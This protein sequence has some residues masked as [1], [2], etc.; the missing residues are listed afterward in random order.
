[1]GSKARRALMGKWQEVQSDDAARVRSKARACTAGRCT[2]A[3]EVKHEG[4]GFAIYRR[5]SPSMSM[6]CTPLF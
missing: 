4:F 2:I 6:A 5:N 3:A 1:M